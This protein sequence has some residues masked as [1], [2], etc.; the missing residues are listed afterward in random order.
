M[1]I[2]VLAVTTM[3]I[4]LTEVTSNTA[5]ATMLMPIMAAMGVAMGIHPYAMMITAAISCSNT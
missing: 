1:V 2:I 5:T 3:A 4:F